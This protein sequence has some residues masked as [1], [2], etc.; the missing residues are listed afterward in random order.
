MR[1]VAALG[2][3]LILFACS[4]RHSADTQTRHNEPE[5]AAEFRAELAELAEIIKSDHPR[6]FRMISEADFDALVA[7][8]MATLTAT[9]DK[10]DVV[11]AMNEIIASI[12]C[13][14]SRLPYFTQEDAL[15]KIAERFPVDVRLVRD[16]L[17]VIDPLSN[18][19]AVSVGDEITR[20]NGRSVDEIRAE[21]FRHMPADQNFDASKWRMFNFYA[22][23][24]VTYALGFPDA[25]AIN[26][27]GA[28]DP[29][30]LKPLDRFDH[31]PIIHPNDPCQQTLC[32]RIDDATGVG[33]MTIRSF[34]FY[35]EQ[36]AEFAKFV[37]ESFAQLTARE[38][39]ALVIDVR[40]N[41]GGSGLAAAYI[42]R[43]LADA[44]FAYWDSTETDERAVEQ[45]FEMQNP[46][47]VGFSGNAYILLSGDTFSVVP[48]F[49]AV[50]KEHGLATLVGQ[51][52]GGNASTNDGKLKHVSKHSGFEYFVSRMR[53]DVATPS[54][55]LD[56]PLAPDVYYAYTVDDVLHGEDSVLARTVQLAAQ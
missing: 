36:G 53:F 49:A 21:I 13:G 24:Y 48:H 35:G 30:S 33:V 22:T 16:R 54:I 17:F 32:F 26:V 25:Y 47:D 6:P 18:A 20:I 7:D 27:A 41:H 51:R 56:E 5:E 55:S 19:G 37:D 14:H 1:Y 46:V 43:R 50:A 8:R 40:G 9:S 28:S 45:L 34:N 42:L 29:I 39:Q 3:I 12:G 23:S 4:P 52:A 11:W 2:M 38:P 44:P 15:V 31:K 10:R